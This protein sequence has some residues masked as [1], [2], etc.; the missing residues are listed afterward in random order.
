MSR[1]SGSRAGNRQG[2]LVLEVKD[3]LIDQIEEADSYHVKVWSGGREENKTN[4]DRQGRGYVYEL[5]NLL[6]ET[7]EEF[8]SG[9]KV[10][11][12]T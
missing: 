8:Q 3:W 4:P 11:E 2:L 10:H 5:M 7:H 9:P 12:E 1:P 6:K